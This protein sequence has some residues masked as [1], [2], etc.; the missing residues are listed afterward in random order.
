MEVEKGGGEGGGGWG[1][2][3]VRSG[4]MLKMLKEEKTTGRIWMDLGL[5]MAL[6]DLV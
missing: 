3:D 1:L 6:E 2:D 4:R 5:W